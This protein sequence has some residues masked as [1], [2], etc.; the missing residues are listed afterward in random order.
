MTGTEL[1]SPDF[2]CPEV[3]RFRRGEIALCVIKCSQI[4]QNGRKEE[5]L[6]PRSRFEYLD[7]LFVIFLGFVPVFLPFVDL[8]EVVETGSGF[9]AAIPAVPSSS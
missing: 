9:D 1:P 8:G 7:G 6:S 5:V 4:V 3:E 2:E